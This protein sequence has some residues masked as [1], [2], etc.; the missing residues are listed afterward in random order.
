MEEILAEKIKL[1]PLTLTSSFLL[2]SLYAL[3]LIILTFILPPVLVGIGTIF[4]VLL[5]SFKFG[6]KGSIVSFLLGSFMV[7]MAAYFNELLLGIIGVGLLIVLLLIVGVS[8]GM[9]VDYIRKQKMWSDALFEN[10]TSAVAMLDKYHR[11]VDINNEFR[12]TFGY[13]R[14]E[15][16]GENLDEI[17]ARNMPGSPDEEKTREVMSGEK[18]EFE[19][20]RY[21]RAGNAREFLIK[22]IPINVKGRVKGIYAIYD[23]ITERKKRERQLKLTQFSV[24]NASLAIFWVN[25]SGEIKYVNDTA[26]ERLGYDKEDLL[27]MDVFQIDANL[28]RDRWDESWQRLK[29]S[30]SISL[31]SQHLTSEDEKIPV[32]VTRHYLQFQE[33]E[34]EFAY[35]Q[36]ISDRRKREKRINYLLYHD[37]LTGLYN[38]RFLQKELE[39]LDTERQL[40][41]CIIM[42]DV[43]GLKLVNDSYG[44]KKGDE[45]LQKAADIL[46]NSVRSEEI[47][48]RWGGDEFVILLPQTSREEAEKIFERIKSSCRKTENDELPVSLGMGIGIK[49]KPR[50]N[51]QE[52]LKEADDN[53]YQDKLNEG[54]SAKNKIVRNLLNTLGAKSDETEKHALRM[55]KLARKVGRELGLDRNQL[56]KLSLL[57]SLHDIGKATISEDILNKPDDL[58]KEEWKIIR[59]HPE[60]GYRIAS[61]TEE[62]ASI[63]EAI[64]SHHERWDGEGYPRGI[65]GEE[66]P[67]LARIISVV[68]TF[69]VMTHERPYSSAVSK[70]KAIKEIKNCV[71]GQFDPKIVEAFLRVIKSN[72]S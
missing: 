10:T 70:E 30:G 40:P 23:D 36:D 27:E 48:A 63:A 33:E 51:V 55:K 46:Q 57:A 13:A 38:H 8:V 41:L 29:S 65:A 47:I 21:D 9:G 43:N 34:Y 20:T 62:F 15:I 58:D 24:E 42:V 18:V 14:E 68:D 26:C 28:S 35:A 5:S 12:R 16:K 32:Q 59:E 6:L 66:I 69:D 52:V 60:R 54:K 37:Q 3:F 53:M 71:G 72:G 19:G 44:H 2:L 7:I 39:R 25:S 22:G 31:E 4:F 50:E 1:G 67:L 45:L 64:L 49:E 61:A 11:I 56:N 17:L